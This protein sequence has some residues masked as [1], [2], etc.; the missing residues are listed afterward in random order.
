MAGF[1]THITVSSILGA[2]YGLGAYY[3]YELPVP[4][5]VLAA[6]L[7]GVSG[8]LP[9]VDSDSGVPLRESLSFA[10]AVVSMLLIHRFRQWGLSPEML[11]LAGAGCYLFVRFGFGELLRHYTVHRGM[12]HSLPAMAIMGEIA[13]LLTVGQV[14][15]RGYYAGAVML[16]YLS[17]LVLDEIYSVTWSRGHMRFKKSFGTALKI[18]GQGWWPNLSVYAKLV[19]LTW[20]VLQEPASMTKYALPTGGSEEIAQQQ[21]VPAS[22]PAQLLPTAQE[23][24]NLLP[25]FR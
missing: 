3:G 23:V 22:T 10:A 16:G 11:V 1:K 25:R 12:F 7:C 6:G 17:H 4:T 24:R 13:Y 18:F 2:G 15:I 14:P 9:D 20:L 8:M 21:A 5:C 19:L